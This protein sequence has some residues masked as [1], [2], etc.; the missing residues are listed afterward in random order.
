M[1][2]NVY[3]SDAYS[4][5]DYNFKSLDDAK[6]CVGVTGC[7]NFQINECTEELFARANGWIVTVKEGDMP[8]EGEGFVDMRYESGVIGELSQRG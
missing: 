4:Y 6:R 7:L 5:T 2:I 1:Y 8:G 3:K